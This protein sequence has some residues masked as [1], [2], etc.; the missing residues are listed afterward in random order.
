MTTRHKVNNALGRCFTQLRFNSAK[1]NDFVYYL[2]SHYVPE[3]IDLAETVTVD[4]SVEHDYGT[5]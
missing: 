2:G 5:G 1:S 3:L 4:P